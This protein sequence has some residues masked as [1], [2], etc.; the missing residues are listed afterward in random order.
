MSL[1]TQL[2]W[3]RGYNAMKHLHH[4]WKLVCVWV[5]FISPDSYLI[6]LPWG[7]WITYLFTMSVPLQSF[8]KDISEVASFA[9]DML[10]EWEEVCLLFF[11]MNFPVI[12]PI[13][14][15]TH[16]YCWQYVLWFS[17]TESQLPKRSLRAMKGSI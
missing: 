11:Y 12:L 4:P 16:N 8:R 6:V 10:S 5:W 2:L 1:G 14:L 15:P 17:T 9:A 3:I 7:R 13:S